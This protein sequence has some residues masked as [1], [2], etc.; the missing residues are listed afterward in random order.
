VRR[1]TTVPRAR[2]TLVERALRARF[3]LWM[4]RRDGSGL[5]Q[6]NFFTVSGVGGEGD[7][8]EVNRLSKLRAG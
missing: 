3:H 4:R 6:F 8:C 2:A 7:S 1:G 5:A